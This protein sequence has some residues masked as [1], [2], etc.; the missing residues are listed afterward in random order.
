MIL[1][2]AH[3]EWYD[4]EM[5]HSYFNLFEEL[6]TKYWI[7]NVL[8]VVKYVNTCDK[9]LDI[10]VFNPFNED[11][12][13]T[14]NS[15]TL[16][17]LNDFPKTYLERTW[18][19]GKY[20]IKVS[21]FE[22]FPN[23]ILRCENSGECNYE[24]RDWNV[25]Q[26]LAKYMNFTPLVR[27]P[28]DGQELGYRDED[29]NYTGAMRD[30]IFK[31]SDISGN[32]RFIKYYGTNKIEFT[33]PAFYTTQ[34]VVVVPRQKNCHLHSEE[35]TGK[36]SHL[37]TAIDMMSVLISMSLNLVTRVNSTPQRLLLSSCLF[38][39]LVV[40]CLFQS[41]LLDAVTSPHFG[42]D[43]DTSSSSTNLDFLLLPWIK[44]CWT[45]LTNLKKWKDLYQDLSTRT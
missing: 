22:S 9:V 35:T 11:G 39:S 34:L 13:R 43:I 27:K 26:N 12:Y 23:A 16:Q 41:S 3:E 10:L 2:I 38:F 14:I 20:H 17:K 28:N 30:L 44:I 29:G 5:E 25:L 19:L 37:D 42:H 7:L 18:N 6:W 8:T 15:I 40:M 1:V 36:V 24:G 33:L 31:R 45:H 32:Q 21:M 4:C